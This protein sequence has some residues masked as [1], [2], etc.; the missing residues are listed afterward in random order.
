MHD[1]RSLAWLQFLDFTVRSMS[2]GDAVIDFEPRDVHLNHNGTIGGGVLFG[3][4]E[5][6]AG[7][8]VI[9]GR[10]EML[11]QLFLVVVGVDMD[12]HRK[13]E[14][15]IAITARIDQ[16]QV[17]H[18]ASICGEMRLTV[19]ATIADAADR[20]CATAAVTFLLRPRSLAP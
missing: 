10:S 16:P 3:L 8:A 19:P 12:F 17:P 5:A 4:A 9:G 15:P 14:G 13:S 20:R 18:V 1:H 11:D 7:C 2:P 6:A